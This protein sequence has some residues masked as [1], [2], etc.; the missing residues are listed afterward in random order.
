MYKVSKIFILFIIFLSIV[1]SCKRIKD[2]NIITDSFNEDSAYLYI[3]N[4]VDFGY[5]IPNTPAHDSCAL[6]LSQKLKSF[7]ANLFVQTADI[8]RYDGKILNI[9]NIIGEFFP[10]KKKRILLFA[11]WDTR[12]YSDGE[13]DSLKRLIPF[14]GANDG[15]SGVAVL[16]EIARQIS[17]NQPE[18]GV[19]IIFFDAEDQGEPL[20]SG[21]YYEKSWC[22]GSQYWS[23]NMHREDYK[24]FVG[25]NLDMVAGKNATFYQED[26]SRYFNNFEL[27]KIWKLAKKMGYENFFA[28]EFSQ[29]LF[30]DYIFVSQNTGIRSIL[31]IDYKK[32]SENIFFTHWHTHQDNIENVDKSTIK[33]VG[34]VILNYIYC[35]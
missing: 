25:I 4:Q 21:I 22:L 9:T 27:K 20:D 14:D 28:D 33:A 6:F 12:F 1:F 8:E 17:M 31:I 32:N 10:E 18:I 34:D 26:N 5:R 11:H 2:C 30:D 29:A 16:L 13:V 3:K 15:G 19:D 7:G 35:N 23:E 24:A